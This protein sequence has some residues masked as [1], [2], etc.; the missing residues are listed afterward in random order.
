MSLQIDDSEAVRLLHQRYLI[1]KE[2]PVATCP[3]SSTVDFV[4]DGSGCLTYRYIMFTAFLAKA[5]NER[6]DILSLQ[7]GDESAGAYNARTLAKKAVYPFQREFLGN[8]LDGSNSDPFAN[9]PGRFARLRKSNPAA[10]GDPKKA[11]TM[12]CDN[13]V[14][15]QSSEE[16]ISCLD[17]MISL[18]L[19]AKGTR[20]TQMSE[21]SEALASSDVFAVRKFMSELLDKGFGGSALV[22][23]TDALHF[24]R[25]SDDSYEVRPHSTNQSGASSLQFSDLDVYRYKKPFMGTE[26]KDKPFSAADVAHSAEVAHSKGAKS[27]LFVA[28]RRSNFASRPPTYFSEAREKYAGLGMYVGVTSID[29]LMDTVLSGCADLNPSSIFNRMRF[30][31]E[32]IGA[33]EAQMW[34]YKRLSSL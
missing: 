7:A 23:V 6:V 22:I 13:L 21:S 26:L 31:S 19:A 8:V 4:M 29:D 9:K 27:L 33:I 30:T 15:I 16:A 28:G 25:F 18:L 10:R 2:N 1:C 20:E 32:R 34:V 17:Y 3:I 5:L 14:R 24:L 12:L 11:L